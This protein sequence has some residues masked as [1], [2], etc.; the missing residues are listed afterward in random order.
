MI[1]NS[2]GGKSIG[3][4]GTLYILFFFSAWTGLVG[5][6]DYMV[7]HGIQRQSAAMAFPTVEGRVL[8]SRVRTSRGSRGTTHYYAMIRYAYSVGGKSYKSDLLRYGMPAQSG[9]SSAEQA[10]RARPVGS[11][12]TVHYNRTNPSDALLEPGV[13]GVDLLILLI[14][15]PFN[16]IVVAIFYGLAASGLRG[17]RAAEAGGA[18]VIYRGP[19]QAMRLSTL[20]PGV[21]ALAVGFICWL[22]AI[23][24][25]AIFGGSDPSIASAIRGALFALGM[26]TLTYF[27]VWLRSKS[28]RYELGI[29]PVRHTLTLPATF[30][31]KTRIDVGF[32]AVKAVE[33]TEIVSRSSKG[34][35]RRRYQVALR[36]RDARGHEQRA[37]LASWGSSQNADALAEW[38]RERAQVKA[39]TIEHS[40]WT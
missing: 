23:V 5:F 26:P 2:R 9:R 1:K 37:T 39:Q 12:V 24:A 10:A 3:I 28:K 34:S 19:V 40:R 25:V 22:L 31:R 20:M 11:L 29:D 32:T 6:F 4:I 33:C 13:H 36:Y 7:I 8:E 18:K 21:A 15:L 38:I 16:L 17:G 30:G 35:T 14:L 27:L